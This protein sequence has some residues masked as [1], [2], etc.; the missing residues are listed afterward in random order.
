MVFA[1]TGRW[2]T[3]ANVTVGLCLVIY[4]HQ[5]QV[6]TGQFAKLNDLYYIFYR[7]NVTCADAQWYCHEDGAELVSLQ[8]DEVSLLPALD[9]FR[10]STNAMYVWTG[11]RCEWVNLFRSVT[12][13]SSFNAMHW[14]NS[15]PIRY[16]NESYGAW[17]LTTNTI[18]NVPDDSNDVGGFI[19]EYEYTPCNLTIVECPTNS[20]Q[21]ACLEATNI[22]DAI[23]ICRPG[24]TGSDCSV[25]ID[26]CL[27]SPCS[28]GASCVDMP[29]AY[30]CRCGGGSDCYN[31]V[32]ECASA[33]CRNGGTC[34][35][36]V[37]GY[38][39]VCNRKFVG[40]HCDIPEPNCHLTGY[41]GLDCETNIDDCITADCGTG[42]CIDGLGTYGCD[43]D[44]TGYI[45]EFC[46]IDIDDC[47]AGQICSGNGLCQNTPGWFVCTCESD[48]FGEHCDQH[49]DFNS[50]L[51]RL[52]DT[53]SDNSVAIAVGVAVAA[54]LLLFGSIFFCATRGF[55]PDNSIEKMLQKR[56]KSVV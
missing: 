50:T 10:M 41:T 19:C 20:T 18:R 35:D 29:N 32:D 31:S 45:G 33:P 2:S 6:S 24:Y 46:E 38:R 48:Y 25:D 7:S 14:E 36:E 8:N 22:T 44:G 5:M 49:P 28:A 39:C 3:C 27:S 26:E 4:W 43:C 9:S 23:C 17:R 16:D 42:L 37:D 53:V 1:L 11:L 12:C 55:E 40:P 56:R 47:L 30:E 13:T 54:A 51:A 34:V 52:V 15:Y 21:L